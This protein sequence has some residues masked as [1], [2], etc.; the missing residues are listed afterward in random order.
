MLRL[1]KLLAYALLGYAL[2]E[3]VRG[4]MNAQD[5]GMGQM[6]GGGN[7]GMEAGSGGSGRAQNITGPGGGADVET[8]EAD[9]GMST[10]RV[11]RG[12]VR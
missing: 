3:F 1:M 9:G 4:M 10:Q 12:V 7:R 2:Y 5:G 6:G 8:M 11:G